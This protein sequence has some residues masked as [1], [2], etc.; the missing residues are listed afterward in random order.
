MIIQ[1]VSGKELFGTDYKLVLWRNS[2]NKETLL[3]RFVPTMRCNFR[4]EY[5]FVENKIKENGTTMFDN[6]PVEDW[7]EA[8]NQFDDKNIELYFW[9]GEPFCIDGTYKLLR[10]WTKKDNIIPGIRIDT[11]CFYAEKIAR[12]CPSDKIKLNCSY[13]MQY[14]SLEEE[15]RKVK[16]LKEIDM[17]GMVNFVA[18]KYNL[19]ALHDEYGMTVKNLIDKFAEIGVFVNVAGDFAF[20]NNPKYER[21]DEYKNFIMQFISEEEWKWLRGVG[22]IRQCCA[23][24]KMFTVEHNGDFTSCTSK[25]K[26][27]NFFDGTL[28]PAASTK[29]CDVS[30]QSI[31]SYA[32]RCD[33]DF[34]CTNSLIHY[35]ERNEEYRKNIKE[36]F[37]DFKF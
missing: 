19:I 34:E 36:P 27:G 21:Y 23:N 20:A 26:F 25:E 28:T 9:G 22:T 7:I 32:F 30:C 6:H 13:H 17:I 35:V 1:K 31:I 37:W 4:C 16:L 14:H 15:F 29:T 24:K 18:S 12:E 3:F 5:C 8:M 11:N 2:M 10:E 33:N